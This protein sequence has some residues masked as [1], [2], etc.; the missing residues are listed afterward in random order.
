MS[1]IVMI[2]CEELPKRDDKDTFTKP[3]CNYSWTRLISKGKVLITYATKRGFSYSRKPF[4]L[5]MGLCSLNNFILSVIYLIYWSIRSEYQKT[6]RRRWLSL[7][8]K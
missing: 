8:K 3:H 2:R 4:D 7:V 5:M 6:L 1:G